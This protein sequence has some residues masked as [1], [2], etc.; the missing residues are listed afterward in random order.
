MKFGRVIFAQSERAISMKSGYINL[1]DNIQ[2]CVIEDIYKQLGIRDENIIDINFFDM[3]NYKGE[4]VIVPMI[5]SP[6]MIPNFPLSNRIIP[7]Y[8]SFALQEDVCDDI[9]PHLSQ[10]AP[11]GC[12]DEVTMEYLRNK[13]IDAYLSGC[14]TITMPKRKKHP[15]KKKVFFVNCSS[16]LKEYIPREL[17]DIGEYI[18]HEVKVAHSMVTMEEAK[19]YNKCARMLFERYREEAS[20]VVTSRLHAAIPCLAMGIPVILAIDNIDGR[21]S[22]VDKLIPVYDSEHYGEIDW[23]PDPINIERE[24]GIF[25]SIF[26]KQLNK[27]WEDRREVCEISQFWEERNKVEYNYKLKKKIMELLRERQ[28][29]E[30]FTYLI[31]GAGVHGKIAYKMIKDFFPQA[32]LVAIVDNF[33]EGTLFETKIIK[34][35]EAYGKDFDYALVTTYPGRLEAAK[36]LNEMNKEKDKEWC[37]FI[38][39]DISEDNS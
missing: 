3:G 17:N 25:I 13:G 18:S 24:K 15:I 14:I 32:K 11:I 29:N 22:W 6:F 23:N 28:A 20:L 31:W 39:K 7:F 36:I 30:T 26:E 9:I 37:Y 34:P 27:L 38:S 5:N 8:I 33:V 2:A 19:Y 4:Y 1:G 16:K 12:R 35:Y 21:F 10:W